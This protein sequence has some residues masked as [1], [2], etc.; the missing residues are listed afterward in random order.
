MTAVLGERRPYTDAEQ[1]RA[2]QSYLLVQRVQA[3]DMDAYAE[4]YRLYHASVFRFI[5]FRTGDRPTAEDLTADT[6]IRALRRVGAYTWQGKDFGWYLRVIARNLTSD[7]FKSGYYRSRQY[8][9][10]GLDEDMRQRTD[11]I[12]RFVGDGRDPSPEGNPEQTVADH[13]RNLDLIAA[14]K[15]ITPEQEEVLVCRFLKG[16]SVAETCE[17]M[18]LS[19]G[20][21]KALQYRAVRALARVL[22]DGFVR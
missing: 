10:F 12:D 18:G 3:G 8:S 6:F 16:L 20:A 21:V 19:E 11:L 7:Y 1:E 14:F 5:L 9:A 17:E 13:L 4:I 2:E 15:R 22:P